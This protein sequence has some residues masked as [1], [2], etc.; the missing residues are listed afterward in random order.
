MGVV[1]RPPHS[2]HVNHLPAVTL[3]IMRPG[4]GCL[5]IVCVFII[6]GAGAQET[7][8]TNSPIE[9]EISVTEVTQMTEMV[10]SNPGDVVVTAQDSSDQVKPENR[11]KCDK[12]LKISFRF[13]HDNFCRKCV[14]NELLDPEETQ[15]LDS[16]VRCRKC[17]KTKFR[18]RHSLFCSTTCP[19]DD[20]AES[21]TSATTTM[22]SHD[23]SENEVDFWELPKAERRRMKFLK[24]EERRRERERRRQEKEILQVQSSHA[25]AETD[26]RL[27]P[28]GNF[29]KD[30][31]VA[32]TYVD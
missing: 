14:D 6:R 1:F 2:E 13:R 23:E 19:T 4:Q 20:T 27:G 32:N 10:T 17:S 30:L 24:R 3:V 25:V 31:I 28:L 5:V 16:L 15:E 26:E 12:C 8:T 18:T 21:T 22:V 11:D 9:T 7:D 29:L